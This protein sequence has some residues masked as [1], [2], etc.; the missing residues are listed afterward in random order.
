M[1]NEK[2]SRSSDVVAPGPRVMDGPVVERRAVAATPD[3][4][5]REV[6]GH[7]EV[8]GWSGVPGE[9]GVQCACGVTF[10]G[11]G[12]IAEAAEMLVRHIASAVPRDQVEQPEPNTA[13]DPYLMLATT[14]YSIADRLAGLAG[15]GLA[16]CRVTIHFQP[17]SVH[18]GDDAATVATV[19]MIGAALLGT[20]GAVR[21]YSGGTVHHHH[22]DGQ[23]GG[24]AVRAYGRVTLPGTAA[25]E[26]ELAAPRLA[27]L[28]GGVA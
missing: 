23:V 14:L 16:D 11:F 17:Q 25:R 28:E 6:A 20:P 27:E 7:R 26:A 22:V 5:Y 13:A 12:T 3:E 18:R 19:D 15:R 2:P 4:T 10:D 24:V 21:P 8:A 9:C 1:P